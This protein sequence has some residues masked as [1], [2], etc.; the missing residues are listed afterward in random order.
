M[1]SNTFYLILSIVIA[2]LM[3][4]YVTYEVNPIY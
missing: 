3:W 1:K 2:I 4:M